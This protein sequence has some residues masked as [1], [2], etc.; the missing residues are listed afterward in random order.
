MAEATLTRVAARAEGA[1][2]AWLA[3]WRDYLL[4]E[5]DGAS[6]ALFRALFGLVMAWEVV[7]YFQHGWIARYYIDPAFHF[8]YLPFIQP[9]EGQ[10]MYWHF[11]VTGALALLVAVGLWYR[12]AA[13]L[14]FLAFTYIF[15]LDK[16]QYLNH[17]YLIALLSLLLAMAPAHR[18][19][20][21]D[22]ALAARPGPPTVPRWSLALLRFQVAVVYFYGGIAKLN[23]DWLAG[24]PLG[25]W[26]S[27]RA[28][29]PLLGPLLAQ[30]WSGLVF[31]WGGLLIDLCVPF[32]LLWPRTFWLGAAVAVGFNLLNGQI[33]SIGIFPYMMIAALVLFPRPGW[34]RALLGGGAAGAAPRRAKAR[35]AAPR[36]S[37][38]AVALLV[39]LHVYALGQLLVPLRHW[40]YPSDVAWSE[41]GHRFAWRMKLR[42]KDASLTLYATDPAS[43]VTS[44]VQPRYWL[45]A[46]QRGK[47]ASRPDM[48]HQFARF[49]ADEAERR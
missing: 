43:G 10:G 34:P 23:A 28:D 21:L 9:W 38:A 48:I 17:F 15:L 2:Y 22:R 14:F 1:S 24:Q 46:R 44:E 39:A 45:T 27:R 49:V 33:F 37:R 36:V 19:W 12:V 40:L 11:I 8:S 47:M 42:D 32:L 31:G 25:E 5:V 7:R 4:A 26:L 18:A 16:A 41:E 13:W 6:L 35:P 30:P 29:L 3:R 20:S